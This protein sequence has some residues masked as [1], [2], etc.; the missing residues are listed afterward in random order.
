MEALSILIFV[1]IKTVSIYLYYECCVNMK[2]SKNNNYVWLLF[3]MVGI[4]IILNI[5]MTI[6]IA[7]MAAMLL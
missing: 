2:T 5:I 3:F 7:G 1:G 6:Y 4:N